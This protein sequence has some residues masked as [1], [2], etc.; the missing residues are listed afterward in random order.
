M[1]MDL[2]L[3]PLS[4]PQELRSR[5][6]FCGD[7]LSFDRDSR[8]FGQLRDDGAMCD[9]TIEPNPI[10]PQMFVVTC[11]G[12]GV[13]RS[14]NDGWERELTFVRAHQLWNLKIPCD[15]TMKNKAIR[16]FVGALP[17]DTPIILLWH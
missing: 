2:T 9:Q 3:I 14:R 5:E 7:R 11:D 8:I 15:T 13:N 17:G 12:S 4:G 1:G 10:P 16:A 6:V